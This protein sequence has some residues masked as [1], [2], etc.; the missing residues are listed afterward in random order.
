MKRDCTQLFLHYR[1]IVRVVWNL[2]FW[3]NPE[4]REWDSVEVFQEAIARLFEGII[5]LAIG[6]QGRIEDKFSPGEIVNFTVISNVPEMKLLVDKNLPADPGHVWGVPVLHV[7][8][9]SYQLRFVRFFDWEQLAPRDFRWLEVLVER[10]DNRPD[11]VGHHALVELDHC[12]I[13]FIPEEDHQN[14]NPTDT[15]SLTAR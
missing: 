7:G 12:S 10:L 3:P 5:L 2:G 15:K 11:L 14:D 8:S 13:W 9:K 4:L 1:E 6:Y